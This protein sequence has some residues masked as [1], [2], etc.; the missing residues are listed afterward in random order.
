MSRHESNRK[1]NHKNVENALEVIEM[2]YVWSG[3]EINRGKTYLSIFGAS[4]GCPRFVDML[5]VKGCTEFKLLGLNFDQCLEKWTKNYLDCFDKVKNELNSWR[6]RFLTVFD[7]IT[8]IKQCVSQS[9][10]TLQQSYP[11]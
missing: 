8:V 11:T 9:S 2:F 1:K 3:L 5:R 6:H 7:K 10:H 4:L